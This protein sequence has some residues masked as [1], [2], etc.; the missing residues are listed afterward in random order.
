[1]NQQLSAQLET[2]PYD[3]STGTGLEAYVTSQLSSKTYDYA[4]NKAL[5]KNYQ[6]NPSS[7]KVDFVC[8]VLILSAMRIPSSDFL[9]LTYM[10]PTQ[11]VSNENIVTIQKC[12][13]A[14]EKGKFRDF[15]QLYVPTQAL[16]ADAVGFVEMVRLFIVSNL[17][18]TFKNMPQG[19]FTQQLGLD[20]VS[21]V[22]F[23][24][25]NKFI[26]KVII[27]H[28]YRLNNTQYLNNLYNNISVINIPYCISRLLM[29]WL[30]LHLTK[31]INRRPPRKRTF[32]WMRYVHSLYIL[33]ILY[34]IIL[35]LFNSFFF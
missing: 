28:C 27:F 2:S 33:Y 6:V 3:V 21:V 20:N 35:S 32:A 34:V 22:S 7:A 12:V 19:I 4:A 1:M 30:F 24:D 8:K 10:I 25:S 31:R 16:F 11:M 5:L 9:S 14:L 26:E 15:W 29:R 18:D 13:D 17:R 23:C